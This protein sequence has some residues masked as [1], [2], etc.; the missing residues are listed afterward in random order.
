MYPLNP[1]DSMAEQDIK[2]RHIRR[3]EAINIARS[4]EKEHKI[5]EALFWYRRARR[6]SI[7][8]RPFLGSRVFNEPEDFANHRDITEIITKLEH[9][10]RTSLG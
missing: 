1:A 3:K 10:Q 7:Y 8:S 5:N 4:M 2:E 6:L 9:Y